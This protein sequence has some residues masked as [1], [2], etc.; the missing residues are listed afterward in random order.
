MDGDMPPAERSYQQ[1][2]GPRS[3]AD[4][5]LPPGFAGPPGFDGRYNGS[6][7]VEGKPPSFHARSVGGHHGGAV[8]V[9]VSPARRQSCSWLGRTQATFS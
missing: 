9:D 1:R 6:F 5:G 8:K 2:F 7:D 3:P 4:T